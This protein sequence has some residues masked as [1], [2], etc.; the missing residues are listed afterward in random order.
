MH[1]SSA[2]AVAAAAAAAMCDAARSVAEAGESPTQSSLEQLV[3]RLVAAE[4]A[5]LPSVQL[6]R[7]LLRQ[8]WAPAPSAPG[9][10][11][12]ALRASPS[13]WLLAGSRTAAPLTEP[14]QQLV[15]VAVVAAEHWRLRLVG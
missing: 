1:A 9:R 10:L 5:R 11:A 12:S 15:V 2:L 7:R 6:A 8:G 4:E 3:F 14:L 13:E